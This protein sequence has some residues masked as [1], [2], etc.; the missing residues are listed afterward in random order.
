M[1][2]STPASPSPGSKTVSVFLQAIAFAAMLVSMWMNARFGWGLA[3]DWVD[4]ITLAVLHVLVDPAA[5]GL[6]VTGGLM[7]RWGWWWQGALFLAIALLLMGYSVL[8][9]YGFMSNRIA[10]TQSHHAIV[11]MQ[12]GQWDWASKSSINREVPKQERQLLRTEARELSKAVQASLSIIPDAQATSIASA[13][14]LP[15]AKVQYTLVMISS[16]IAQAIKFLCLLG[17][18]MIW[19]Q[20]RHDAASRHHD[21]SGAIDAVC[22]NMH[23]MQ[24]AFASLSASKEASASPSAST[25]HA[26]DAGLMQPTTTDRSKRTMQLAASET[27]SKKMSPPEFQEYLHQHA[28][29]LPL[30]LSQRQMALETGWHQ[31]SVSRKLRAGSPAP[32]NGGQQKPT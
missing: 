19:P 25:A 15:I 23:V 17:G 14:G 29:G 18:V 21:A 12:R 28:S 27:T 10:M 32:I 31:S 1:A 11:E 9:V 26:P 30:R 24:K 7:I 4:R 13:T 16:G 22:V 20:P 6:I 3:P 8:S 2:T 5:A